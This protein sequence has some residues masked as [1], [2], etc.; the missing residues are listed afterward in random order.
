LAIYERHFLVCTNRRPS[1]ASM[2]SCAAHGAA[3][4]AAALRRARAE[5]GLVGSVF[6]TETMCLG[7]C[8]HEGAT[9]V[10]YPEAVWYVGVMP[11]DVPELVQTHMLAGRVVERLRSRDWGLDT[12]RRLT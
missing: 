8:P 6:V 3:D 9:I 5:L 2:P 11:A 10:V 1:D 7:V 4:I 12:R